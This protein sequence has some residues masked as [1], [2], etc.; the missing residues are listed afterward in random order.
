MSDP[1]PSV[2]P[3]TERPAIAP[4]T[5][6]T[7]DFDAWAHHATRWL[8]FL[9]FTAIVFYI[10]WLILQPFI[11]VILWAVVL[12]IVFRPIDRWLT[13]RIH[14]RSVA[15]GISCAL[16]IVT[17]LIPVTFIMLTV[18]R[19]AADV[20]D[21]LQE[22]KSD[23]FDPNSQ[24]FVAKAIRSVEKYIEIDRQSSQKYL[25]ER[26]GDFG[27]TIARGTLNLV[28]GVL[29]AV[30]QIFFILF[31]MFFLFRDGEQLWFGVR[32][33]LPLDRT[34]SSEI[35]ARTMDVIWASVYGTVVIAIVQGALGGI[36]FWAL[37]VPSALLWASVMTLMCLIP[38]LGAFVV[39]APVAV[40][41]VAT[42]HPWKATILCAWGIAVIGTIDNFLRPKLVGERTHMHALVI[43]FSVLGG[44]QVFGA[45]GII[46]GPVIAAVAMGLVEAWRRSSRRAVVT[47]T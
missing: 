4:T 8:A 30:I 42:G 39:W 15:A 19:E 18:A 22:R 6:S 33:A 29:G 45:L 3:L 17:I 21:Y 40:Y 44:L 43:F 31:T 23:W 24:T 46:A 41:F 47:T 9:A 12:V 34:E 28:G 5:P 1:D 25:A 7:R 37:G 32:E 26:M 14:S 16:V 36:A 38:M 11:N 35:A 20:T 2:A 10:C 27:R 13:R